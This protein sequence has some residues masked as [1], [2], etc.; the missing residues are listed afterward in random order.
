MPEPDQTRCCTNCKSRVSDPALTPA[1]IP[2]PTIASQKRKAPV[3]KKVVGILALHYFI[4]H[5]DSTTST[6]SLPTRMKVMAFPSNEIARLPSGN[7]E[8]CCGHVNFFGRTMTN[9]QNQCRKPGST[10][11]SFVIEYA[12]I[13][14]R[15]TASTSARATT[16][17]IHGSGTKTQQQCSVVSRTARVPEVL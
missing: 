3:C 8:K 9:E 6:P 5:A 11:Y 13:S 15:K 14:S 7:L 10:R 4:A 12:R 17:R 2:M 16:G 1:P